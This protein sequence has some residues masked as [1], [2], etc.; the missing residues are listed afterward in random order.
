MLRTWDTQNLS[1]WKGY[2][3]LKG[4]C[5]SQGKEAGTGGETR[6][7]EGK[8]MHWWWQEGRIVLQVQGRNLRPH[9]ATG[10]GYVKGS[11]HLALAF[12]LWEIEH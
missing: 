11:G 9:R 2:I 10:M 1:Y 8:V 6:H 5:P 4:S 12:V 7:R 3:W